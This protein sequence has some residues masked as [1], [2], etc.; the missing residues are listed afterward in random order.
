VVTAGQDAD[1]SYDFQRLQRAIEYLIE[2]HQRLARE[3]DRVE[4]ER[5]ALRDELVEREQRLASLQAELEAERG[6][7][8]TALEGVEKLIGRLDQLQASVATAVE[9]A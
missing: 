3:R 5:E 6:R 8:R 9:S 7:R 1:R 4:Q 2:E